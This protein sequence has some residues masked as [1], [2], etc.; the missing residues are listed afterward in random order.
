MNRSLSTQPCTVVV[1]RR[2]TVT[3]EK[4]LKG[5]IKEKQLP[6]DFPTCVLPV[7]PFSGQDWIISADKSHWGGDAPSIWFGR[8]LLPATS[9][10]VNTTEEVISRVREIPRLLQNNGYAFLGKPLEDI[11]A[12][13]A[14][15]GSCKQEIE[16]HNR[17]RIDEVFRGSLKPGIMTVV[18]NFCLPY[19]LP[20]P[21]QQW[22][23]FAQSTNQGITVRDWIP[24]STD[25]LTLLRR[26]TAA[27]SKLQ[28]RPH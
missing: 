15:W 14:V 11:E 8:V 4:I 2:F 5:D 7:L 13:S 27:N 10:N 3:V 17:I 23:I 16:A 21:S 19:N 1:T 25:A 9:K 22:V 20:K 12:R 6:I 18:F 24:A 28:S 26:H